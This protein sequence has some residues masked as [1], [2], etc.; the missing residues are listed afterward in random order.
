MIQS[1]QKQHG[2]DTLVADSERLIL[3]DEAKQVC[4]S[5]PAAA[6]ERLAE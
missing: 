3:D 5:L 2:T 6:V 1:E 4:L